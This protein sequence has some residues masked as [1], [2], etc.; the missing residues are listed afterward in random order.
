MINLQRVL[1]ATDFSDSSIAAVRQAMELACAFH[2]RFDVLHVVEEPYGYVGNFH[3]YLPEVDAF[4]E[5]LNNAARSQLNAVLTAD[6]IDRYRAQLHLRT[7]TPS[8]EIVRFAKDQAVDLIV[9]GTHGR[10]PV[11]HALLGSVAEKVVRHAHCAVL[12]VRTP[13]ASH[14]DTEAPSA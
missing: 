10:G 2:A 6:E 7:G 5:T 11:W 9:I 8:V 13:N 3:G 14:S 1:V 4:R 12:T